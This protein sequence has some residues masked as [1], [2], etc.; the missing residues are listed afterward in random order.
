MSIRLRHPA[1]ACFAEDTS[2]LFTESEKYVVISR[3]SFYV[4]FGVFF[5]T[6][7]WTCML[8]IIKTGKNFLVFLSMCARKVLLQGAPLWSAPLRQSCGALVLLSAHA[9]KYTKIFQCSLLIRTYT[10]ICSGL[11]KTPIMEKRKMSILEIQ[12]FRAVNKGEVSSAEQAV[13]DMW[14]PG[15][16]KR[17]PLSCGSLGFLFFGES[18]EAAP[19]A[20]AVVAEH[21][22]HSEGEADGEA[23]HN[24]F[25]VNEAVNQMSYRDSHSPK[26]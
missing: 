13:A 11:K 25:A 24:V 17:P 21:A 12:V 9:K 23:C 7:K 10:S 3:C 22:Y 20:G 8:R 4:K 26:H 2:P 1:T 18:H 5:P 19:V 6:D 16:I 14:Q 15:H